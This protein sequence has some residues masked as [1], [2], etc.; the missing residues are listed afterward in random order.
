MPS[1]LAWPGALV[2]AVCQIEFWTA[3]F[4]DIWVMD[5][6]ECRLDNLGETCEMKNSCCFGS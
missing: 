1:R 6:F 3:D 5:E 4:R 2:D